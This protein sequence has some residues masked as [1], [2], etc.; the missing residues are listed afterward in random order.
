[1]SR[2]YVLDH[3]DGV[4]AAG[5]R[6]A[7]HDFDRLASGHFSVELLSRADFR[8]DEQ[9]SGYVRRTHREAIASRTVE[10]RIIAIG[11][12]GFG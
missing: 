12:D 9:L 8:D 11:W 4:G 10:G 5:Q 1:M 3:H 6:S 7:G 2:F